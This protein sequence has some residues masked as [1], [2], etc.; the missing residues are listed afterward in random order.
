[1]NDYLF[2]FKNKEQFENEF[3][4]KNGFL[5]GKGAF[6]IVKKCFSRLDY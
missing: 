4:V 2:K 5:L 6:G 3:N 1:M